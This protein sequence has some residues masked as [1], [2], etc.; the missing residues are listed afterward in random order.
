[1]TETQEQ[2]IKAVL[3]E[4]KNSTRE[5]ISNL[6]KKVEGETGIQLP[7]EFVGIVYSTLEQ[8]FPTDEKEAREFLTEFPKF[9]AEFVGT[10]EKRSDKLEPKCKEMIEKLVKELFRVTGG[11]GLGSELWKSFPQTWYLIR[12]VRGY[13]SSDWSNMDEDLKVF[14]IVSLYVTLYELTLKSL[15]E[16]ALVIASKKKNQSRYHQ[17]FLN[18]YEEE[19]RKGRS[20]YRSELIKFLKKENFLFGGTCSVLE[21]ARFRDKPAHANMYYNHESGK[22]VVGVECVEPEE[23]YEAYQRL[24]AFYCHLM[25]VYLRESGFIEGMSKITMC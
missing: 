18:R 7:E 13:E 15:T 19:A 21:D 11:K 10:F 4:K 22:V 14:N 3:A 8:I 2:N 23:F 16:F 17:K 9:F 6:L 1:M 24:L 5:L 25:L 12:V 20:I